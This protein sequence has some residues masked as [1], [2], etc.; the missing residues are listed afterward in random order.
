[1][2]RTTTL[3]VATD[4]QL[5]RLFAAVR[6]S[7]D[8]PITTVKKNPILRQV[9]GTESWD[10]GADDEEAAI[11]TRSGAAAIPSIYA[12]GGAEPIEPIMIPESKVDRVLEE[13]APLRLRALPHAAVLGITALELET[14]SVVLLGDK[15]PPA[16]IVE[17]ESDDGFV[18]GLPSEAL[19]PLALL[20]AAKLDDVTERWN[21]LLKLT[22]RKA[23]RASLLVLRELAREAIAC[24]GHVFTHMPS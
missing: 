19:M 7:L 10:P 12:A 1:M 11:S 23:D 3:F 21:A 17:T 15:K 6:H 13:T 4:E 8:Q 22:H 5:V 20:D 14:L 18:D 2:A 9:H 24:G 16:R